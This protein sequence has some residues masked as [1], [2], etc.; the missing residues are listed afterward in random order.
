V[1]HPIHHL[2]VV[3]EA[4]RA[5]VRLNGMPL[6]TVAARQ[7]RTPASFAPPVN[8][9]LAGKRNLVEVV[10]D[11]STDFDRKPLS[12]LELGFELTVRRFEQG[13]IVEPGGGDLVTRY[14]LPP[15]LLT[16]IAKGERTPP[17]TLTHPFANDGPD[18]SAELLDA[19]PFADEDALEEYAMKL[20]GLAA[21]RDVGGLLAEYGPKVRAWSAAYA[22]PEAVYS[23]SLGEVLAKF[24]AAGPDLAF[25]RDDVE[26]TPCS[27][28][29]VWDLRRRRD[30]PLLRTLPGPEGQRTALS[31]FVAPRGGALRIV[32]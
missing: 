14:V 5:D 19:E 6:G 21:R 30:L 10:L 32:R 20:R 11:V 9:F 1:A 15:E 3:V 23:A 2:E 4:V 17:I 24:V 25:T 28:G 22:K 13:D 26:P 16:E 18:F 8:P 31:A 27:G 7:K 29:R 12:F